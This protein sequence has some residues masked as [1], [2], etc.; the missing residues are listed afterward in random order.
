KPTSIVN[1][2]YIRDLNFPKEATIGGVIRDNQGI[3]AL[4]GFKIAEGDRVVVCCLPNAIRKIE[5][6]FL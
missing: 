4:G 3:I 2:K 6:L 1:G 5:K